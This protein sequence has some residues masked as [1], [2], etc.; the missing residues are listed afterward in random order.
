MFI[1]KK[2]DN[3]KDYHLNPREL[4]KPVKQLHIVLDDLTIHPKTK[5]IKYLK[6]IC[7]QLW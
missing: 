7:S 5:R 2:I 6:W 1:P 3:N 4:A